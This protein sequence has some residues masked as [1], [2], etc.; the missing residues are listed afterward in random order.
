MYWIV[1]TERNF[2]WLIYRAINMY[3]QSMHKYESDFLSGWR[4]LIKV[5][6]RMQGS[7][8]CN[9]TTLSQC[10]LNLIFSWC[11]YYYYYY[12]YTAV[13]SFLSVNKDGE[14]SVVDAGWLRYLHKFY[15]LRLYVMAM[16]TVIYGDISFNLC[17][18]RFMHW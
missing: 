12:Y 13:L 14:I 4:D 9:S 6:V 11:Y 3:C 1:S 15:K 16:A 17:G 2:L 10:V 18:Q 7:L 8:E 5:T